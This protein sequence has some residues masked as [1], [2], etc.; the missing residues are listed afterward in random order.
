[1]RPIEYRTDTDFQQALRCVAYRL[2]KRDTLK[3]SGR[4]LAL[5]L[6]YGL[7]GAA[8]IHHLLL[9]AS[10]DEERQV[11]DSAASWPQMVAEHVRSDTAPRLGFPPEP[12]IALRVGRWSQYI[13]QVAVPLYKRLCPLEVCLSVAADDFITDHSRDIRQGWNLFLRGRA[14]RLFREDTDNAVGYALNFFERRQHDLEEVPE[15]ALLG[16]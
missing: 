11:L 12:D 4:L 16:E 9:S 1:M 6:R 13:L 8:A 10:E 15:I 7:L 2:P 3:E 5:G 14:E